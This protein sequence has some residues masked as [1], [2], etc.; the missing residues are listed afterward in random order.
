MANGPWKSTS[1]Y[2]PGDVVIRRSKTYL[3]CIGATMTAGGFAILGKLEQQARN[4]EVEWARSEVAGHVLEVTFDPDT[5]YTYK[6]DGEC[7]TYGKVLEY[8][9][10]E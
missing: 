6:W 10:V 4:Q 2:I 9:R 5:Q 7:V 8:L 3:R 1:H